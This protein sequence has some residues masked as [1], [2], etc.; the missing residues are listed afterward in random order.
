MCVLLFDVFNGSSL[1]EYTSATTSQ[2]D[3]DTNQHES[4]TSQHESIRPR[5]YHSLS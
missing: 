3:S 4:D 2:H 5:N 1:L